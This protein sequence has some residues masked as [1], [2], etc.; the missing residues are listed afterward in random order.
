MPHP[1]VYWSPEALNRQ[2]H[3]SRAILID[4]T[5]RKTER[6]IQHFSLRFCEA[7][8]RHP[9]FFSLAQNQPITAPNFDTINYTWRIGLPNNLA[10]YTVDS[11]DVWEMNQL[12]T[13]PRENTTDA[14]ARTL[15]GEN[16][17]LVDEIRYLSGC[18][19]WP[20]KPDMHPMVHLWDDTRF[21]TTT[22]M[23]HRITYGVSPKPNPR[24]QK[25]LL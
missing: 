1:R 8:Q 2:P 10:V 25:A 19:H 9:R 20:N 6:Y 3:P 4:A 22:Y 18:R 11:L 7:V 15:E 13:R 23:Y 17:Q 5:G 12:F 14:W 16:A 21:D 24:A